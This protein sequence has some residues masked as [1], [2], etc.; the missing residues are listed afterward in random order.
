MK[1]LWLTN[2]IIPQVEKLCNVSSSNFGGWLVSLCDSLVKS[3]DIE[4]IICSPYSTNVLISGKKGNL[5]YYLFSNNDK[6][7]QNHFREI[8]LNERPEIIHIFGTE[9]KHTLNMVF[10]CEEFNLLDLIVIQIQGL[11]SK[12]A[13]HYYAFL[14]NNV[15]KAYSLRDLLRLDNIR[16]AANK[17][18]LNGT[19]EIQALNKVKNVIGRTDWD[20]ACTKQINSNLNY[21][22]CNESLRSQ[23]YNEK[24]NFSEIEKYSIFLSQSSYPIKGFHLMLEAMPIILKEFPNAKIY[25]TGKNVLKLS[26]IEKLKLTYYQ[27]Y[28]R[29]LILKFGISNKVEFLGILNEPQMVD[30]YRKSHVFVSASSIENS[31]NSVGEAMIL[32]V[33]TISSDVGGVKNLLTHDID[34]FIY[35][36]DAPYMLA[37][38]VCKIF[39]NNELANKFSINAREHAL[40]THNRDAVVSQ[41]LKIYKNLSII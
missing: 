11:I 34:G 26:G 28:L 32:G 17:M 13:K 21:F 18:I 5:S 25:T 16:Q 6:K 24:W 40:N 29:E 7:Q 9:Y 19:Y 35:Q 39:R 2:V 14:P 31:P 23:F 12:Y 37:H 30:R 10:V 3:D 33:P 4:L 20:Y 27:L 36:P 41:L 22:F 8:I 15:I 1:I 38:Y